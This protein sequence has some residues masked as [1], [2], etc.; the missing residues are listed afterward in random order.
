MSLLV[1]RNLGVQA[2]AMRPKSPDD[3]RGKEVLAALKVE[4][5]FCCVEQ[6]L[7]AKWLSMMDKDGNRQGNLMK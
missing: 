7:W 3:V 2:V 5:R 6:S 4:S 1:L